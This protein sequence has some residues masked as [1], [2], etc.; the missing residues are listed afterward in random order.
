MITPYFDKGDLN[1]WTVNDY[2]YTLYDCHV[3]V[4]LFKFDQNTNIPAK[5]L[6]YNHLNIANASS[7]EIVALK[8]SELF[9]ASCPQDNCFVRVSLHK[10]GFI[11]PYAV[12]HAI[13]TYLKDG[14]I[15]EAP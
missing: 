11:E 15:G 4:Q 6:T 9:D 2:L 13:P 14:K 1:V 5:E 10:R 8:Q 3:K 12:N 7:Q